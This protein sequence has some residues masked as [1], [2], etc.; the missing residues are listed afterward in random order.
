MV[1]WISVVDS[2]LVQLLE[3]FV[4]IVVRSVDIGFAHSIL[5]GS[6]G[7]VDLLSEQS[8]IAN[9]LGAVRGYNV[10]GMLKFFVI[11]RRLFVT[12]DYQVIVITV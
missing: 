1:F 3:W 6:V 5:F 4:L 11:L 8:V 9:F 2:R 7:I 12:G 10:L